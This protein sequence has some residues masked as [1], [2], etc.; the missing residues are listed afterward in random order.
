M[1]TILPR[2]FFIV[3]NSELKGQEKNESFASVVQVPRNTLAQVTQQFKYLI[4]NRFLHNQ[5]GSLRNRTKIPK[6]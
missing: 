4:L 6:F 2:Y 5:I 3:L 1:Q